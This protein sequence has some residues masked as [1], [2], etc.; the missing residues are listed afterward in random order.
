MM[1]DT[2]DTMGREKRIEFDAAVE[3]SKRIVMKKK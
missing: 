2:F 1:K 3:E